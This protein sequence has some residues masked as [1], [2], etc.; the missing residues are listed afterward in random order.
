M[1]KT[2]FLFLA[3]L[4]LIASCESPYN[5][6]QFKSIDYSNKHVLD[7]LIRITP[8]S[9]DTIFLGFILGMS[10]ADYRNHIHKLRN[11]GLSLTFSQSNR[12]SNIAG[13]FELGPGYTFNT[14]I[15]ANVSDKTIT[16]QGQYFL[17]PIYNNEDKLIRLNVLSIENWSGGYMSRKPNW[18]QSRIEENSSPFRNESLKKALVDNDIIYNS[19]FIRQKG[20]VLI[21]QKFSNYSYVPINSI[22]TELLLKAIEKELIEEKNQTIT[23]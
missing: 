6:S 12:F 22:L 8:S 5:Q 18:F 21:F 3:S 16:G 23:F 7:S 1:R 19:S 9:N 11:D 10:K 17:E 15:S 4:L 20:N 2:V 13:T 14:P